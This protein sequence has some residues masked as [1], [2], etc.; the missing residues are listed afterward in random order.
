MT[1]QQSRMCEEYQSSFLRDNGPTVS[2]ICDAC[3]VK[4]S[5]A[6]HYMLSL[7]GEQRLCVKWRERGGLIN[8]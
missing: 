2:I 3:R 8:Q 5:A 4:V 7:P 1:S 6:V